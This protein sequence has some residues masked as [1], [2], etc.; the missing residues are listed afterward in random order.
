M[1]D[2]DVILTHP[3]QLVPRED[4]AG[5]FRDHNISI[6]TGGRP[7]YNLRFADDIDLMDASN[8][9]LRDLTN[10]LVDTATVLEMEVSTKKSKI[11]TNF[12]ADVGM[13]S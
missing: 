1:S 13:N 4:H 10:R 11:M 3:V 8:G 7:I 12:S 6:S 5:T 2:R 9:E